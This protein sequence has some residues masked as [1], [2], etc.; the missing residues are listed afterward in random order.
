MTHPPGTIAMQVL[1]SARYHDFTFSLAGIMQQVP[2]GT[3]IVMVKGK[4]IV[5]GVNSLIRQMHGD[6]IMFLDDDHKFSPELVM[7]LLAHNVDVVAPVNVQ[8]YPPFA[9]V[10]FADTRRLTWDDL[11]G[12]GGL[13]NAAPDGMPLTTGK[14]GML[15]RKPVLDAI[16]D[17]WFLPT[18]TDLYASSDLVFCQRVLDAGFLVHV[19]LDVVMGHISPAVWIPTRTVDGQW[20]V[21]CEVNDKRVFLMTDNRIFRFA[22]QDP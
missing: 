8:R 15:I 21:W 12:S 6:W 7:R 14:A 4:N 2:E 11:D 20:G 3:D 19:D 10:L 9:P 1:E 16:G 5:E 18:A 17:P 22:G 13:V